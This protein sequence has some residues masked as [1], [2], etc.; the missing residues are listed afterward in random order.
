MTEIGLS[1]LSQIAEQTSIITG[2]IN[3]LIKRKILLKIE[4]LAEFIQIRSGQGRNETQLLLE[5]PD[6]RN[7]L[8]FVL[9][10]WCMNPCLKDHASLFLC[11]SW[12]SC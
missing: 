5:K 2:L 8:P 10:S 12:R 6:P 1:N 11:S 9:I 7:S 3:N 4:L